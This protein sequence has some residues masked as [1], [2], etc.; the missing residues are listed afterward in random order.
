M[1]SDVRL[2]LVRAI[3]TMR[4]KRVTAADPITISKIVV[5]FLSFPDKALRATIESFFIRDLKT[6][7]RKK[8]KL[9]R[10]VQQVLLSPLNNCDSLASTYNAPFFRSLVDI[11]IRLFKSHIWKDQPTANALMNATSCTFSKASGAALSFFLAGSDGVDDDEEEGVEK[12]KEQSFVKQTKRRKRLHEKALV[13]HKKALNKEPTAHSLY[14]QEAID[15]IYDPCDAGRKLVIISRDKSKG[16]SPR[17]RLM[18]LQVASLLSRRHEVD[19]PGFYSC[20]INF[21]QPS[22]NDVTVALAAVSQAV[23]QYSAVESVSQVVRAI[24]DRF[25]SDRNRDEEIAIGITAIRELTVRCPYAMDATLLSDLI[26]YVDSRDKGVI[27]ASRSLIQSFREVAPELLP[28]KARGRP[29]KKEGESDR[30]TDDEYDDSSSDEHDDVPLVAREFLEEGMGKLDS[31]S[32]GEDRVNDLSM[33]DL[34]RKKPHLSKE[35]RTMH[36]HG[37]E[38]SWLSKTAIKAMNKSGG[39]TNK[40]KQKKKNYA[41]VRNSNSKRRQ[42]LAAAGLRSRQ[43]HASVLRTRK[44]KK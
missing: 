3:F 34:P 30:E 36:A 35:E 39:S 10:G 19:V 43:K 16:F 20:L 24:A 4:A 28:K 17:Q 31:G 26:Q 15:L 9:A 18:C 22:T 8:D 29:P 7:L 38:K 14:N 1:N 42:K 13:E 25:I 2:A 40:E 27:M 23:H 32:D 11:A 41:M 6:V 44:L 33:F 12:P 21:I 5:P 37:G